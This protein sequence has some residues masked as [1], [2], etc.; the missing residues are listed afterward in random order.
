MRSTV[1]SVRSAATLVSAMC[2]TTIVW[3]CVPGPAVVPI[4]TSVGHSVGT[5]VQVSGVVDDNPDCGVASPASPDP[6]TWFNLLPP[7]NR[8][9]PFVGYQFWRNTSGTCRS[10]R[11][12]SYRALATF[13][14]ASVSQLRGLV[15]K[16]ELIVVTRA[17]P[18]GVGAEPS[19]VAM[20]GGAESL[21]R[22]G[23]NVGALPVSGAGMITVIPPSLPGPPTGNLR[24]LLPSGPFPSG[25]T[26][27]T[28]T[29]PW[30][31]G[32][33]AGATST[34]TTL[35]S[36]TGGATFSVD[37]TNAAVSALNGGMPTLSWMLTGAVEGPFVSPTMLNVDCRTSYGFDLRLTHL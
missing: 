5:V 25:N 27:F 33:I 32:A 9:F 23:P 6:Q 28:M 37:V 8:T 18:S 17:L 11:R 19:C 14:M 13:N 36:G 12:D 30:T 29:R 26:V 4:V 24:I 2:V 31:A 10:S 35:A 20:I 22:F 21:A 16:A 7:V 3:A 1:R 15:T 34:T